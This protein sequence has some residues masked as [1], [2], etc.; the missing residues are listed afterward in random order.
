MG[1]YSI[2][3]RSLSILGGVASHNF[4]VLRDDQGRAVAELHGLATDRQTGESV[5]I[6]TDRERHSL[7][8]WHFIHDERYARDFGSPVAN[9]SYIQEGQTAVRVLSG[10]REEILER[11]KVAAREGVNLLN[12]QDRDYPNFG[13]DRQFG[14]DGQ[15]RFRVDDSTVNSNSAYR[16]FGALMVGE[17]GVPVFRNTL[18]PGVGNHVLDR[19]TIH[20]LQ[21][22]QPEFRQGRAESGVQLAHGG[23][24]LDAARS[25]PGVVAAGR[26]LEQASGLPAIPAEKLDQLAINLA[27]ASRSP[28]PTASG[29]EQPA[30]QRIAAVVMSTNGRDLIVSDA[31]PDR[32]EAA[33]ISVPLAQMLQTPSDTTTRT[34]AAEAQAFNLQGLGQQSQQGMGPLGMGQQTQTQLQGQSTEPA[35]PEAPAMRV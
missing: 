26:A 30:L 21:Y 22:D 16:T 10:S 34:L 29:E 13:V 25:H 4:W 19:T 1:Q 24:D 28:P 18:Q 12:A 27:A 17:A 33:R 35:K 20:L 23:A 32:P 14:F 2:E 6:G 3:A 5:P 8:G 31:Q 11:W 15:Y 7:R 9:T